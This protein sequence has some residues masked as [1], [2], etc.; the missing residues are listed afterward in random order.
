[1]EQVEGESGIDF[2]TAE[3]GGFDEGVGTRNV[4]SEVDPET[5]VSSIYPTP[6]LV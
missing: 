1:M 6:Q 2:E 3:G 4:S 5:L